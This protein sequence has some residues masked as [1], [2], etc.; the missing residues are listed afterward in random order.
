LFEVHPKESHKDVIRQAKEDQTRKMAQ[1]AAQY[2][3]SI[4]DMLEQQTVLVDVHFYYV[5]TF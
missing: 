3:K 4:S 1:L 5:N 2:E